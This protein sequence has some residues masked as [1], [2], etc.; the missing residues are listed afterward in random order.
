[1]I[2]GAVAISSAVAPAAEQASWH[3]AMERECE[4][5]GLDVRRVAAAQKGE[6]PLAGD[7]PPRR[8][9]DVLIVAAAVGIFIWLAIGTERPPIAMNVF[10]IA[11]LMVGMLALLASCGWLLWKRT[12]FS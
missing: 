4:R 7:A 8:W 6:D 3:I 9:W 12:R 1:M 11:G 10:W 2:L 5:Y